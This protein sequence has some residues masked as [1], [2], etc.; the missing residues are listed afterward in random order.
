MLFIPGIHI[1]Q[2]FLFQLPSAFTC[3]NKPQ[4]CPYGRGDVVG[5]WKSLTTVAYITGVTRP[6]GRSSRKPAVAA[7]LLR[8]H[9][10]RRRRPGFDSA[11]HPRQSTK[12]GAR[13]RIFALGT[14]YAPVCWRHRRADRPRTVPGRWL[15]RCPPSPYGSVLVWSAASL[16]VRCGSGKYRIARSP[17]RCALHETGRSLA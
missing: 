10:T 4:G 8:A 15:Y 14:D 16:R 12:L 1:A 5:A 11:L 7:Q 13:C 3:I 9:C 17:G 2:S 6:D